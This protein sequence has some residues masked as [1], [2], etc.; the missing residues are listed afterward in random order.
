MDQ[1]KWELSMK[2]DKVFDKVLALDDKHWEARFTKAMQYT[3]FPDFLGKKK[4]AIAHFETLVRQQES[5]PVD[6]IQAQT[7]LYLGNLLEYRDPQKAKEIWQKGARRHLDNQELQKRAKPNVQ[8]AAHAQSVIPS[9]PEVGGRDVSSWA[10]VLRVDPDPNVV[11]D[12][13]ARSK[14][15]ASGWPWRVEDKASGLVLLLVPPGEFMMGSPASEAERGSDEEQHRRRITQAFYLGETEVTQAAWE[16]VMRN[17]PSRF[18]GSSNP[19]E[20]VSWGDIQPFLQKTGLSLPSEAQWEYA[21][22]A[23]TT[24]PFSFGATLTAQQANFGGGQTVPVG[25]LGKNAWG[26]ADMHGNVWEWCAD[27]YEAY[28]SDGATEAPAAG[29]SR[30][31]RGGSWFDGPANCRAANRNSLEPAFRDDLLG[32]PCREDSVILFSLSLLPSTQPRAAIA[33]RR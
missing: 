17:N 20:Q 8:P 28:P 6:A 19:V 7:Y 5:M 30:V 14:I 4:D 2:A 33:S 32:F 26:F 9:N 21:C 13:E 23:G 24:T 22:R 29:A 27:G 16:R 18:Q 15:V 3:F 11:T 12:A 25:T 31:L 1:S 10:K